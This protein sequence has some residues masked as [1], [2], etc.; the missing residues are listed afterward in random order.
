MQGGIIMEW[1]LLPLKRYFEFSGRS[2]R[3][4]YWMFVLLQML[5]WVVLT[6][7]T[8][9]VAGGAGMMAGASADGGA[10]GML[11]AMLGMGILGIVM[12]IVWLGLLVPSIAVA[13][14]RL[15]DTNRSGFWLFLMAA[16]Y[17]LGYIM[18]VV[19]V[20]SES[21]TLAAVG[22]IL[23]LA[24]LIGAIALLVFMCL[25]GTVGPNRY[26]AD[27]K[28]GEHMEANAPTAI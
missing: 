18:V 6:I 12:M 28:A 26:G 4:E 19:G 11:G 13:V 25:P 7:L 3:K 17:I 20:A 5:I 1:M 2:R 22:G 24:G 23:S 16:P 14:R 21:S 27:P 10:S 8:V 15:H 9:A